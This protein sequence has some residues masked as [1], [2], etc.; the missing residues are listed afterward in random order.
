MRKFQV[1]SAPKSL[2][3]EEKE[4]L[5]AGIAE[6]HRYAEILAFV[7]G[8]YAGKLSE[9]K[10]AQDEVS[11]RHVDFDNE[12]VTISSDHSIDGKKVVVIEEPKKEEKKKSAK[13]K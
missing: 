3:Q 8:R 10:Y 4:A 9:F 7:K 1:E 12:V 6:F 11:F 13:K 2:P 5:N